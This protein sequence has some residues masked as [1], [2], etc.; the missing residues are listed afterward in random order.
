[1]AIEKMTKVSIV[2]LKSRE[3]ELRSFLMKKGVLHVVDLRP[4][5]KLE[6]NGNHESNLISVDTTE[7]DQRIVQ[8]NSILDFFHKFHPENKGLIS[9]FTTTPTTFA[10]QSD[11]E[12]AHSLDV[13]GLLK[14]VRALDKSFED[15]KKRE[16]EIAHELKEIEPYTAISFPPALVRESKKTFALL[17]KM[18]RNDYETFLSKAEEYLDSLHLETLSEDKSS[19][20]ILVIGL[21]GIQEQINDILIGTHFIPVS[22]PPLTVTVSERCQE[23]RKE[24]EKLKLEQEKIVG[25]IGEYLRHRVHVRILLEDYQNKKSFHEVQ[26]NFLQTPH[27]VILEGFVR[28]QDVKALDEGLGS[29]FQDI[30]YTFSSPESSDNV[31]VSLKNNRIFRPVEL[32]VE[33]FG[34]PNYFALDP[35]PF[36]F[37]TFLSFFGI[38]LGDVLYGIMLVGLCTFLIRKYNQEKRL[39][40]FLRLFWYAGFSTTFF[41]LI[42]GS[43]GGDLVSA[44]YLSA[45]NPLLILRDS[46]VILDPMGKPL[47]ALVIAIFIGVLNQFYGIFLKVVKEIR[48]GNIKN[49]LFDGILWYPYLSGAIILIS[50]LFTTVNPLLYKV[51]FI[52]FIGGAVG[53]VLTQGRNEELLLAKFLTG[54]ASLYGIVG[55]YGLAGFIGD[56]LS[57]SRLLAL[58]L[59][60]TI[61]GMAFNII[62]FLFKIPVIWPCMIASVLILGH[63]F[64]FIMNILGAFIH[65]AR[66]TLLEFFGRFYDSGGTPFRAFSNEY[67]AL[68]IVETAQAVDERCY[69]EELCS[70]GS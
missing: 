10:T 16:E 48:Q 30:S 49:A 17:G 7:Y 57:Y 61:V 3:E 15:S 39:V 63:M 56:C 20:L 34:Y 27:T 2:C 66:L 23:L 32:L 59:T 46:L 1:M 45:S 36:I 62:A 37:W 8:L 38:C 19:R 33:M 67:A 12:E 53:L 25:R 24:S 60:T 9:L 51:G 29:L 47:V 70:G 54:I 42:T 28:T 11:V 26:K 41:G 55:S 21:K 13:E 18:N 35:T 31:P 6:E 68:E 69:R 40:R 44:K 4:S 14:K 5:L 65:P 52:L 43:W 50:S 58:G 22:L 64:N